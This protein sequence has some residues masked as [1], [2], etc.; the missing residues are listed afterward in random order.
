[1][2]MMTS[3][4]NWRLAPLRRTSVVALCNDK[5]EHLLVH[6]HRQAACDD[7]FPFEH[8]AQLGTRD[9][10]HFVLRQRQEPHNV[11]EP[12]EQFRPEHH[13]EFGLQTTRV[14]ADVCARKSRRPSLQRLR[15][16]VGSRNHNGVAE[17][18]CRDPFAE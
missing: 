5:L 16:D 9:L 17:V 6:I 13:F 14:L 4:C 10:L 8:A 3:C 7:A 18:D 1:M 15:A 11:L 2:G 12:V